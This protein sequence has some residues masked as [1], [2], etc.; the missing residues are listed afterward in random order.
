MES[1]IELVDGI[2]QMIQYFEALL[3]DE[4]INPRIIHERGEETRCGLAIVCSTISKTLRTGRA[5]GQ[6]N[7]LCR[8]ISHLA[9]EAR[10][11]ARH[12]EL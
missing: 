4:R 7:R 11:G 5:R 2:R 10:P 1:H 3:S 12:G 9:N 8:R 6:A